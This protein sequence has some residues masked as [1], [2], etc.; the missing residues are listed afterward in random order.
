MS[1]PVKIGVIGCGTISKAY[2]T[3]A[4]QF[5]ILDVIAC[6]DILPEA[7]QEK[8]TEYN[9]ERI[10]SV[11]ELLADPD[12][13]IV[14]NLTI[15]VA[16]YDVAKAALD[17]GKSVY[18]EKPLTLTRTEGQTILN[19]ATEKGLLVG[20]APDTFLGGG[21]QTCRQ[22]IDDGLIG[23]PLAATAFMMSSGPESWHPNPEFYYKPGAGPMFD[24]GPYYLTSLINL[25]GPVSRVTGMTGM[26]RKERLITSKPYH[27]QIIQV[28]VPTHVVGVMEFSGGIIGNIITS[29]DVKGAGL[30]RIEVYGSDATLS[31]PDPNTFGGEVKVFH[32]R[33][34]G[35]QAIPH[36][37]GYLENSRSLGLADMAHALRT[38]RPHRANGE[39][40]Y[41]VLDLM[42]AFHNA[43]DTGQHVDIESG[44][45]R[46]A[47]LTDD[48]SN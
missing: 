8:G 43:A 30:P 40:A 13:E 19:L 27:G 24:M 37:H 29:F 12:I 10:Y 35:W 20:C 18:N 1:D 33:D 7:A 46:P 9:I 41:H 11:E 5:E 4:K 16:H 31:V 21:Q 15:P 34:D 32:N 6:A 28:E 22:A 2:F 14:L 44:C 47:A 23:T 45:T 39:M 36:S 17:A 3:I 48:L 42:H 38:N 25:L 26:A